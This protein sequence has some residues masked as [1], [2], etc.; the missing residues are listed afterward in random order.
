MHT[1]RDP[2]KK[3]PSTFCITLK[4]KHE[5]KVSSSERSQAAFERAFNSPVDVVRDRFIERGRNVTFFEDVVD[6]FAT[7]WL[8][9]SHS[10]VYTDAG[11]WFIRT[12]SA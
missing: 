6:D 10:L 4:N 12:G 2:Y 3:D 1:H 7:S 5:A 8:A 11:L 9:S